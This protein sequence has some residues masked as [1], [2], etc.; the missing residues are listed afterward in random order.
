MSVYHKM[1]HF[2]STTLIL[3]IE[4]DPPKG[5]LKESLSLLL[6]LKNQTSI[7]CEEA[8]SQYPSLKIIEKS[9]YR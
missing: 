2:L 3:Y 6:I 5:Y 9:T 7:C 4:V 1:G 8:Q